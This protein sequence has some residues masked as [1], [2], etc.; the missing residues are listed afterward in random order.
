M[1]IFYF[2]FCS[3]LLFGNG[4]HLK[5]CDFDSNENNQFEVAADVVYVDSV[6]YMAPELINGMNYNEDWEI[7][8]NNKIKKSI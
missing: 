4:S 8:I 2:D 7:V 3:L 1:F 6:R 5:L